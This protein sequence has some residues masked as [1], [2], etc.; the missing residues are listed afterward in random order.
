MVMISFPSQEWHHDSTLLHINMK[1]LIHVKL[2]S[3]PLIVLTYAPWPINCQGHR[4]SMKTEERRMDW[5]WQYLF[6]PHD[7]DSSDLSCH[8]WSNLP[9]SPSMNRIHILQGRG[10]T[11]SF[12]TKARCVNRMQHLW[13]NRAVV[14]MPKEETHHPKSTKE[15]CVSPHV[16]SHCLSSHGWGTNSSPPCP[17]SALRLQPTPQWRSWVCPQP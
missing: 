13:E 15:G 1:C 7:G 8:F 9:T 12:L 17:D 14:S 6:L 10:T 2:T 3:I 16:L 4:I 5:R 11:A